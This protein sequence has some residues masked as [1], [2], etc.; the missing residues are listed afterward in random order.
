MSAAQENLT[1]AVIN[2]KPQYDL[3]LGGLIFA[4]ANA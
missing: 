1:D 2:K 3:R 4:A